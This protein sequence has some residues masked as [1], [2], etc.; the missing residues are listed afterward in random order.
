MITKSNEISASWKDG[1]RPPIIEIVEPL[2]DENDRLVNQGGLFTRSPDGIDIERW[3]RTNYKGDDKNVRMIK[4][5]IPNEQRSLALRCL[6]R[7]NIN[8]LSLFP[9]LYGASKFCNLDLLID[10]Y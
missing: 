5:T 4:F 1:G 9:D 7:M 10:K 8:H 3:V 6:N 2:S